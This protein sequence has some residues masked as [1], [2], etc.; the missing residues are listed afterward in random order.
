[1]QPESDGSTLSHNRIL[2]GAAIG[3]ITNG[4]INGAIQYF[5]LRGDASIPLTVNGIINDEHTVLGAAV[6]L[7]VVLAM[8]LTVIAH[9][10][11]KAPKKPF[12]PQALWLTI[13]HGLFIFGVIVS[14]AVIW[15]RVMGSMHVSLM[16]AVVVLGLIAGFVAAVINYMTI[17]ASLLPEG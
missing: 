10:T 3:G 15:Q 1:M 14:T 12:I 7:A 17:K 16:T 8:I 13:K 5:M 4:I 6:P 2:R 9:L 11:L